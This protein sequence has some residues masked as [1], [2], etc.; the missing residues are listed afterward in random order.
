MKHV[1]I[2]CLCTASIGR[3]LKLPFNP[4]TDGKEFL[5][6]KLVADGTPN[7]F[8]ICCHG[9]NGKN[10][11]LYVGACQPDWSG[12]EAVGEIRRADRDHQLERYIPSA[13]QAYNALQRAEANAVLPNSMQ[14]LTG[15]PRIFQIRRRAIAEMKDGPHPSFLG[16]TTELGQAFDNTGKA[17]QC[18]YV[19][20]GMM[21]YQVATTFKEKQIKDYLC[22][23]QWELR[24]GYSHS[25]AEIKTSLQCSINWLEHGKTANH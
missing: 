3:F 21:G 5:L 4:L 6:S 16:R 15:N 11:N 17:C 2:R 12:L 23:F 1:L 20:Q 24:D 13:T 14:A 7:M 18:C 25:C 22:H 8:F 9:F 10:A 19:C